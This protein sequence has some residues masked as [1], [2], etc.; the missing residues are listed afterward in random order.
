MSSALT[1]PDFPALPETSTGPLL[2]YEVLTA[3]FLEAGFPR[4]H[5]VRLE[6]RRVPRRISSPRSWSHSVRLFPRFWILAS[7]SFMQTPQGFA[8]RGRSDRAGRLDENHFQ[9]FV[10]VPPCAYV[11]CG[12]HCGG[13]HRGGLR[14]VASA[15][16]AGAARASGSHS[17]WQPADPLFLRRSRLLPGTRTASIHANINRPRSLRSKGFGKR[18]RVARH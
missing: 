14:R 4:H 1:G 9:P 8:H 2:T 13:H 7:N 15:R 5:A 10:P 17:R 11:A 18:R 12:L 6:A 16:T 3:F